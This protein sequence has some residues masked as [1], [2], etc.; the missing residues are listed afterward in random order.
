MPQRLR[1]IVPGLLIGLCLSMCCGG[2]V[3]FNSAQFTGPNDPPQWPSAL[4]VIFGPTAGPFAEPL[5]Y[6]DYS[7]PRMIAWG[8]GL[9]ALIALHPWRPSSTTGII[10]MIAMLTWFLVGFC[11]T[12][13]SV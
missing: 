1:I 10:S 2:R 13:N 9:L 4:L 7:W 8:V 3:V 6:E 5:A 11:Y 12:Y